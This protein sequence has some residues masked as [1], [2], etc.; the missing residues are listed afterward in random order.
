MTVPEFVFDTSAFINSWTKFYRPT[1]F[2]KL[3]E[4]LDHLIH[5][6]RII[7]PREVLAELRR[8]DDAVYKW[9]RDRKDTLVHKP[10]GPFAIALT[11]VMGTYT[12]RASKLRS[13]EP[14]ADPCVIAL[15]MQLNA[16]VVSYEQPKSTPKKG[17]DPDPK[18][19]DMCTKL[20]VPHLPMYEFIEQQG[21]VY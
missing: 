4:N 1:N 11:E 19:P 17:F 8:E 9:V 21:W 2:R 13:T 5:Q 3:W 12:S 14:W 7:I 20:G 15:A 10:D 18:L 16:T 6:G